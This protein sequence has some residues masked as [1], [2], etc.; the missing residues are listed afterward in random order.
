MKVD[1]VLRRIQIVAR[2]IVEWSLSH[3][4][5]FTSQ[6][7]FVAHQVGQSWWLLHNIY[8]NDQQ[9]WCLDERI[10]DKAFL[11][12]GVIER[13]QHASQGAYRVCFHTV[14]SS[15]YDVTVSDTADGRITSVR[16]ALLEGTA[17]S[18]FWLKPP[19]FW[20]FYRCISR[21]ST[22]LLNTYCDQID[23]TKLKNLSSRGSNCLWVLSAKENIHLYESKRHYDRKTAKGYK[24]GKETEK[25][26]DMELQQDPQSTSCR[27]STAHGWQYIMDDLLVGGWSY[28]RASGTCINSS[29]RTP[30]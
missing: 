19:L 30:N 18:S 12:S 8:A 10:G 9:K 15:A 29:H 14:R 22:I 23:R 26:R 3:T 2:G 25:Q 1:T 21:L 7:P 6:C 11:S 5:V 20:R 27:S 4:A 28:V 13:R 16:L 24:L 17:D